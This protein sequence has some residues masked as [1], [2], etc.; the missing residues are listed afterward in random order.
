MSDDEIKYLNC[1]L[2][3]HDS[4]SLKECRS[5]FCQECVNRIEYKYTRE[6]EKLYKLVTTLANQLKK[7]KK[8]IELKE[9]AGNIKKHYEQS[10]R[11]K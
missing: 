3:V 9:F 10:G 7:L 6:I 11:C 4:A 5:C 1:N 2:Q 8:N